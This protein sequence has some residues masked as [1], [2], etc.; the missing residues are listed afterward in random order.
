L[1]RLAKPEKPLLSKESLLI[2]V[3]KRIKF[4][5]LHDSIYIPNSLPFSYRDFSWVSK[6]NI[7]IYW[8]CFTCNQYKK[9]IYKQGK[10]EEVT[11]LYPPDVRWCCLT[12]QYFVSNSNKQH[13]I[14]DCE[15]K[16]EFK[17]Y[18]EDECLHYLEVAL[19]F[20]RSRYERSLTH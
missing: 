16:S 3:E 5:S 10:I 11:K 2:P 13:I 8:Q 4:N 6:S 19:N 1:L 12:L 17:L 18:T 14:C 15:F 20:H 7:N 9:I